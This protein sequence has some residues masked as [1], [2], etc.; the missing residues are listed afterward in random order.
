M[1]LSAFPRGTLIFIAFLCYRYD[2]SGSAASCIDHVGSAKFAPGAAG[3]EWRVGI[4]AH[5]RYP[6][7][8]YFTAKAS[9]NQ[10]L[11]MT[12]GPERCHSRRLPVKSLS[13]QH[14]EALNL[15]TQHHPCA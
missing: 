5:F 6:H 14:R 1:S 9:E 2:F 13:C 4:A 11:G 10:A 8:L 12:A 15:H 3:A 7:N